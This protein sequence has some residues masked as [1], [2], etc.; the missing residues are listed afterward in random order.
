[1]SYSKFMEAVLRTVPP[2]PK[3]P[4]D[5]TPAERFDLQNVQTC[6]GCGGIDSVIQKVEDIEIARCPDCQSEFSPTLES[7]TKS[8]VRR[9]SEH[10]SRL[11]KRAVIQFEL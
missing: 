8:V 6:P 10:R 1:M 5:D 4:L 2:E 9:I 11:V 3:F 7:K